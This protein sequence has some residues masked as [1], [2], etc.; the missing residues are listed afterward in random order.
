M[1]NGSDGILYIGTDRSFLKIDTTGH[2]QKI[3]PSNGLIKNGY[4]FAQE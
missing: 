4:G 1:A 2:L 3:V